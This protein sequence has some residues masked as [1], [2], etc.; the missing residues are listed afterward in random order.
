MA[1]I[2]PFEQ[3]V[4]LWC[5]GIEFGEGVVVI[6]PPSWVQFECA[7][8]SASYQRALRPFSFSFQRA[9]ISSLGFCAALIAAA[10]ASLVPSGKPAK[11]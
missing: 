11:R 5:I 10:S 1:L 2:E 7:V 9:A 6:D 4:S 3:V 8:R